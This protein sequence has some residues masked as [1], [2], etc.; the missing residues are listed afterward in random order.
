MSANVAVIAGSGIR[1]AFDN[2]AILRQILYTDL[3]EFRHVAVPGVQGH[4]STILTFS[5]A[6]RQVDVYT[7]RYH[8]YEGHSVSTTLIP[9]RH[10]LSEGIQN[11]ILTN[12]VGGLYAGL[13]PGDVV[14]PSDLI[15]LTF[16][17]ADRFENNSAPY[18]SVREQVTTPDVWEREDHTAKNVQRAD[19]RRVIHEGWHTSLQKQA[20]IEKQA[21]HDGTYVQVMGPSYETRAE[22]R[23]LRRLGATTVGMSTAHEA[24][25]AASR[26]LNVT[27]VSLV[28]NT[29]TDVAAK[30][31][32][33]GDVLDVAAAASGRLRHVLECAIRTAPSAP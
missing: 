27:V 8:L 11:V 3:P 17:T 21:V 23:F 25:Y 18:R 19:Y 13:S 24:I 10:I 6:G 15:D 5:I 7:G 14:A 2:D 28:T 32:Q 20:A 33:H 29:C 1:A 9:L 12:A 4:G 30:P 31:V 26:G 16:A 22:I